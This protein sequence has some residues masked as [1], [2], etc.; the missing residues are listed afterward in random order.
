MTVKITRMVL[1]RTEVPNKPGAL[2]AV[3]EPIAHAGINL[4]AVIKRSVPGR[5]TRAS[6]EILPGTGRRAALAA[7]AAGFSR[8]PTP[9]LLVE[10]ANRPGL[11]F[12]VTSAIAWTGIKVRFLS[13]QVVG[14]RYAALLGFRTDDEC[15]QAAALIRKVVR[16]HTPQPDRR[17]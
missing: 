2:D 12:A 16:G 14:A 5:S 4:Q 3:L 17:S 7:Q 11:V 10:G 9:V 15:R 6:V 1:W 13:A 8:S